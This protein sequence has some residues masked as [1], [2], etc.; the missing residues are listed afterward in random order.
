MTSP[1]PS[2]TLPRAGGQNVD[3]LII[4]AGLSGLGAAARLTRDRPGTTLAVLEMRDGIGGTWDLFRSP[5]VRPD[6]D[7]FTFSYPFRPWHGETSMGSG[8]DIRRYIT[9]TA[10]EFGIDP[11]IHFRTK[12]SSAD[13]SSEEQRWTVRA[14]T[15]GSRVTWTARFLFVCAGYYDY[16][17]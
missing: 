13:W 3:V 16:D 9:E 1:A 12:V 6:P 7:M 8:A 2:A 15:D 10:S 5:G 4:G 14:E 11:H 17:R